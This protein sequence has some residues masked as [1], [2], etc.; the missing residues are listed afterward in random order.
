MTEIYDLDALV[1]SEQQGG[2]LRR[3]AEGERLNEAID[4]PNVIE[5][6]ES[7]GRSEIHRCDSFL[8]QLMFHLLKL[9]VWRDSPAA[10]HWQEEAHSFQHQ[11]QMAFTASMRQ[12]L[13]LQLDYKRA[14]RSVYY[15]AQERG[16]AAP[17][18]PKECPFALDALLGDDFAPLLKAL[19]ASAPQQQIDRSRE[20]I[21]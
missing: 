11:A 13:C 14:L 19:D 7:M 21:S 6:I 8:E 12:R 15:A 5:E 1:W 3:M 2:L 16:E 10:E 18:L 17:D 9:H 20:H 4:W